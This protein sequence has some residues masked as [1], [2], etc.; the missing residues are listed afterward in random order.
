MWS[1]LLFACGPKS[2]ESDATAPVSVCGDELTTPLSQ[3][4]ASTWPD[5]LADGLETYTKL[6]GLWRTTECGDPDETLDIK[7]DLPSSEDF[8]VYTSEPPISGCG[9]NGDPNFESD[10]DYDP[11]A[12]VPIEIFVGEYKD[13]ALANQTISANLVLF[14]AQQ[15]LAL[16]ACGDNPVDPILG[17]AWTDAILTVRMDGA[18]ALTGTIVLGEDGSANVDQCELTEWEF[19]PE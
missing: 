8:L 2:D 17:S 4:D 1:V 14:G 18:D 15:A 11:I 13:V 6:D 5:G 10:G 9:C 3:T 7:F 16:R 12:F 19:I